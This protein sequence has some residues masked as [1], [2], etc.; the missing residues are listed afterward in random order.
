[1]VSNPGGEEGRRDREP[2]RISGNLGL[3][4]LL[5][6]SLLL[7]YIP[8]AVLLLAA[9]GAFVYG[10]YIFIHSVDHIARPSDPRSA[11]RSDCSFWTSTSS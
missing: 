3:E 6:G 5:A 4:R 10:T 7:A 8:V 11:I 2:D 9:L 1:M